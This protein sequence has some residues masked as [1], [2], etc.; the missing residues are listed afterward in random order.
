MSSLFFYIGAGGLA[1]VMLTEALAVIGR[2]IG[3]PILGALEIVQAAILP[4]ACASMVVG[5]LADAH[6]AV[7]LITDRLSGSPKVWL[8]RFA[9]LLSACFF[10]GLAAG[11]TWL[12]YDMW[13]AYEESEVLLIPYRPL[14]I[15]VVLAMAIVTALFAYRLLRPRA[16]Q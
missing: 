2:H 8:A 15:T 5:T 3:W 6:A 16:R 9:A 4:A 12:A 10:A 7:H 13:G 1:V 14:R 11:A